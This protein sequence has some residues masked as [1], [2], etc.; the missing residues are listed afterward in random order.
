[1]DTR[2]WGPDGWK[3]LHSIAEKYPLHPTENDKDVYYTFFD[4]LQY[5]L[6]CIYCRNSF[7][8][9]M[10]ELDIRDFLSSKKKLCFWLYLIH[11]KVNDKL[12]KQG[13]NDKPN[14]KFTTIYR[15]YTKLVNLYN[16][17][18]EYDIPGFDFLYSIIFNYTYTCENMNIMRT[19]KYIIFFNTLSFVLPFELFKIVYVDYI[20]NNP[21]NID[22]SCPY[23]LKMWMFKLHIL[24]N[25]LVNI[26]S[27]C[28]AD[29]CYFVDQY[30]AKCKNKTCRI[31][32]N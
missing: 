18:N 11:N 6:P 22:I 31:K 9:Y 12:K 20:T 1:M 5:I 23:I 17:T 24:Y 25:Q 7:S 3:L 14:P 30:R 16:N 27:I 8:Q 19:E 26:N 10:K 4:T 28:F 2:F 15:R 13:I 21:I 32:S 29:R